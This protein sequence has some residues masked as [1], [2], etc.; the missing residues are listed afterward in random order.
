[1]SMMQLLFGLGIVLLWTGGEVVCVGGG[2]LLNTRV[3]S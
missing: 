2:L 3:P 1:M